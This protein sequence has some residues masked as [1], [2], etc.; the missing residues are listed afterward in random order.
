MGNVQ[1]RMLRKDWGGM[2]REREDAGRM[3]R[4][5]CTGK[6]ADKGMSREECR[7]RVCSFDSALKHYVI[8]HI[9]CDFGRASRF[10]QGL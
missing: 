10:V 1:G 4:E 5:D 9:I 8:T 7:A 3:L 2:P 6:N